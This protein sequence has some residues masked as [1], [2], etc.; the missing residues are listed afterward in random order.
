MDLSGVSYAC[1]VL[2]L[3]G[4]TADTQTLVL[5]WILKYLNSMCGSS[6]R[7]ADLVIEGR[8]MLASPSRL[9]V[10]GLKFYSR[11]CLGDRLVPPA[12]P[13]AQR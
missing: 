10:P 2:G 7:A 5:R 6:G 11:I 1:E 3:W 9:Q 4:F 13:E 8:G 12:S